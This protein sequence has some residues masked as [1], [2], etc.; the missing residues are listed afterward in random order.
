MKTAVTYFGIR[1]RLN[2]LTGIGFAL[3]LVLL[4]V[5]YAALSEELT[6]MRF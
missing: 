6:E 5:D 4:G 2:L 3:W 1:T